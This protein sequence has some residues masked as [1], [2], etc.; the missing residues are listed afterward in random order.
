M[1]RIRYDEG[2]VCFL[3]TLAPQPEKDEREVSTYSRCMLVCLSGRRLIQKQKRFP[4]L[5]S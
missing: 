1:S 2:L 5:R 4:G 3:S